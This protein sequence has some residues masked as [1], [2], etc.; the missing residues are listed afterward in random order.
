M[1]DHVW[2]VLCQKTVT[3]ADTGLFGM[4]DVFDKLI[5]N[6]TSETPD[7]EAKLDEAHNSGKKGATF[8]A[9]LRIVTQW[10][11][12]D[13][14]KPEDFSFRIA[15]V[16]PLGERLFEQTVPLELSTSIAQRITIRSEQI[17]ITILGFYW[18]IVERPRETKGKTRWTEVTKVP[19]QVVVADKIESA[20]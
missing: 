18:F 15:L 20:P 6:P 4:M 1:A 3:D 14:S 16:D 11:R 17:S 9:R 7:V 5:L 12:S 19:L 2:T 8:P 13:A 10:I